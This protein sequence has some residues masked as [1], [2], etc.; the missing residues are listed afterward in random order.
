MWQND[1]SYKRNLHPGCDKSH[2]DTRSCKIARKE[3]QLKE[4]PR[5][6]LSAIH[7]LL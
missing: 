2:Y 7:K 6:I 4:K 5:Q 3:R 1:G